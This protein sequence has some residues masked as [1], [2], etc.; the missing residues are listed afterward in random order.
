M[1]E[2][3]ALA[4]RVERLRATSVLCVGDVM[5]DRFV[6]GSVDRISPEAPIPVLAIERESAM[7]GGAGNVVRNLV[8]LGA[9]PA[10]ISVVGDD[11]PGREIARLVGEHETIAPSLLVEPGRQT[12]IKTR[13]FASNQQLLRADRETRAAL[14][15]SIRDQVLARAAEVLAGARVMVLSDY[16][17]GVLAPEMVA[18]LIARAAG[19]VVVVDPKGTDY[20][21]YAGA[22]IVT[23]NRKELHEATGMA[24]NNDDEVVAAARHLIATCGIGSVLV[25]RSQDGMTLVQGDGAVHHLPAEAREVFDVSGAGDTVVATL[26]AALASGASLLDG[27]LLANVAAGI[28]VAKVGTA[29]AYADELVAVLHHGD[30]T[31]GGSK[32]VTAAAAADLADLWRRKGQKVGFTNGCFDLLHPGHVSILAQARA[33][34]DRLVVGL[35]SDASVQ[36]LKGPTRPVQSEAARA[37]VL[38]SLASVDLVVIFGEDTPLALIETLRPDVL[39]KGADYTVATVVGADLVQGWGGKVVLADLVDGQSTT[40]TIRRMNGGA[41]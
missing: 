26:A 32:I 12:T 33:A 16:G 30:L 37:T 34:C 2:L 35:N 38:S 1:T 9:H 23:P 28:V 15:E 6:Y 39:V 8:A 20:S 11:V 24:V 3:S 17:K 21:I 41:S 10:F 31:A 36:R 29:V 14:D 18:G 22:T 4:D 40:N 7:L 5:L 13:F 19:K 25:T 27:A